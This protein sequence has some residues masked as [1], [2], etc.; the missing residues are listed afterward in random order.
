MKRKQYTEEQIGFV[1][2]QAETGTPIGEICRKTW[3]SKPPLYRCKKK[4]AGLSVAE[5]RQGRQDQVRRRRAVLV[6]CHVEAVRQGNPDFGRDCCLGV[7]DEPGAEL[8]V[9]LRLVQNPGLQL[10]CCGHDFSFRDTH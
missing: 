3:I 6:D 10:G 4:F 8:A 5:L 9:L 2:S 1:L 7:G